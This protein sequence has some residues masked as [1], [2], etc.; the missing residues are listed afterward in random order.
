M[1]QPT[2]ALTFQA[3]VIR[4]ADYLGVADLSGG[5]AAMPTD[6]Y[7]LDLCKRLV[8]DGYRKF[9]TA[10]KWNFLTPIITVTFDPAGVTGT[11]NSQANEY[12]MPAGFYGE[13]LSPWT[14]DTSGPRIGIETVDESRIREMLAGTGNT[15]GDPIMA[16]T[17]PL[18]NSQADANKTR[19]SVLVWPTPGT[20][21]TIAAR[22]RVFPD[23]LANNTD[24]HIAGYQFDEAV[25]AAA[26]A[27]AE[28]KR[29]GTLGEMAKAWD[30]ALQT[31]IALD[32]NTTPRRAGY[33]GDLSD[34]RLVLARHPYTGVD[35]YNGV[36]V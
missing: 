8:N 12:Y 30:V 26:L 31:A 11:V 10:Y 15:T 20:A 25:E 35:T 5:A 29:N 21:Y 13:L 18:A 22:A 14:Y 28:Y 1:A 33:V 36:D 24:Y 23:A 16:A 17:R 7:N 19:W 34:D 2:L 9:I 27:C 32:N 3:L 4:V 6:A